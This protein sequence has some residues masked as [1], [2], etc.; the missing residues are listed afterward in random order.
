MLTDLLIF[1]QK[2]WDCIIPREQKINKFMITRMGLTDENDKFY[3]PNLIS[4]IIR[5]DSFKF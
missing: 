3:I 5:W 1:T 4:H 2:K